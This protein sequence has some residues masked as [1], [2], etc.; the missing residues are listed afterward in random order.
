MHGLRVEAF[1]TLSLIFNSCLVFLCSCFKTTSSP[2]TS[3]MSCPC[4]AKSALLDNSGAIFALK[5][6][7]VVCNC[8]AYFITS[9]EFL[10]FSDWRAS[11][12]PNPE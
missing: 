3:L 1:I 11:V 8:S 10:N 2:R 5:L 6:E 9:A 7:R 12:C 4:L